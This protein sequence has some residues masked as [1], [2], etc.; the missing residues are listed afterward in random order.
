MSKRDNIIIEN[1][2][3]L[4]GARFGFKWT[5]FWLEIKCAIER[6]LYGYDRRDAWS[7]EAG[8]VDRYRRV[9]REMAANAH[10]HPSGMTFSEWQAILIRM[11]QLL[12]NIGKSMFETNLNEDKDEFMELFSLFFFDLWD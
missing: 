6:A 9:L 5:M 7:L 8:F 2:K 12:D 1:L 11:A 3:G 4:E 10:S